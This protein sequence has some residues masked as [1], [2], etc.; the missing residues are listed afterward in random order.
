[1]IRK[2]ISAFCLTSMLALSGCATVSIIDKF[3]PTS[4]KSEEAILDHDAMIAI[5]QSVNN[6]KKHGIYWSKIY[7]PHYRR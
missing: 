1:M 3:N 6:D 5:G 2:T 7:L 4:P